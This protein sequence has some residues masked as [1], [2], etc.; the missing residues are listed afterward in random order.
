MD[1]IDS[2]T[3]GYFD[4]FF[5]QFGS[6]GRST[7]SVGAAELHTLGDEARFAI[8]VGEKPGR[9]PRQHDVIVRLRDG[10]L[11]PDR[12]EVEIARDDLVMWR[13]DGQ[14]TPRF[15][16]SG[17]DAAG[18]WS[19]SSLRGGS[20]YTHTFGLPGEYSLADAH[21][22]SLVAVVVVRNPVLPREPGDHGAWQ[23]AREKPAFIA[24]ESLP[25]RPHRAELVVGQ[26]LVVA[27]GDV[28]APGITLTEQRLLAARDTA[29]GAPVERADAAPW[30]TV[31]RG[32]DPGLEE[33]ENG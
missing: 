24:L 18:W 8:L 13:A 26:T 20:L 15:S 29:W 9:E 27:V 14:Q 32:V 22:G 21:G 25:V 4:C 28:P 3:L 2:R 5:R 17:T 23:A 10:R 6:P 11:V 7:Y 12:N 31:E 1:T 16:L 30:E 33:P 19:S